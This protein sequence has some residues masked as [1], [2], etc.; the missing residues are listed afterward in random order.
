MPRRAR[1]ARVM[2]P[3]SVASGPARRITSHEGR[4]GPGRG[5]DCGVVAVVLS[6]ARHELQR[7]RRCKR[8]VGRRED[9]I[10]PL[11]LGAID[12][13]VGAMDELNGG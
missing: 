6:R 10:P 2:M 4:H 11:K 1:A 8:I 5:A 7:G 13:D 9:A 12:G 3:T